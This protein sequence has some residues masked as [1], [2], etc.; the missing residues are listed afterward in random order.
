MGC[1]D[2]GILFENFLDLF[3]VVDTQIG[4]D[5][6]RVVAHRFRIAIGDLLAVIENDHVVGDLHHH[7]HVMLDQEDRGAVFAT[8]E[9]QEIVELGRFTRVEACC[10]LVEAKKVRI[11]A[12]RACDL[13]AA[14]RA[15]GKVAGRI[16]C[17][18]DQIDPLHPVDGFLH[19]SFTGLLVARKSQKAAEG[20]VGCHHKPVVLGDEQVFQNRHA[21]EQP[22]VLEGTRHLRLVGNGEVRH[23]LE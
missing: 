9:L 20:E 22:D 12:H 14:L 18:V 13:E 2:L 17:T 21:G 5:H 16:V 6:L 3:L 11:G 1:G 10:R 8:D 4:C 23:P 7:A 19:R 15:I